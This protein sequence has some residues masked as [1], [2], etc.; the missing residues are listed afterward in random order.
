MPV[1]SRVRATRL[2]AA[3][4]ALL[5]DLSG[6]QLLPTFDLVGVAEQL[7]AG[8]A[9]ARPY[10]GDTIREGRG[11]R[12]EV[13]TGTVAL[14]SWNPAAGERRA[15]NPE[16]SYAQLGEMI[17]HQ[18][19]TVGLAGVPAFLD[20]SRLGWIGDLTR[21]YARWLGHEDPPPNYQPRSSRI[22]TW[23]AR[24]RNR[25]LRAYAELDYAPVSAQ[26]GVAGMLTLTYPAEWEQVVPTFRDAKRHLRKFLDRWSRAY[27]FRPAGLW[28]QEF[29]A[30]G[31][32][33]FH[34]FVSCPAL[35]PSPFCDAGHP[36]TVAAAARRGVPVCRCWSFEEWLSWAWAE[37]V[38]HPDPGEWVR[39][40]RA[41]TRVDFSK[42]PSCTDGRRLAVYFL[43]HG[44]K[45]IAGQE[46]Q[47]EPPA[48]WGMGI[49]PATGEVVDDG[50]TG[51]F[52]GYWGLDRKVAS[53]DIPGRDFY[54]LRRLCRRWARSPVTRRDVVDGVPTIRC[55]P[56]SATLPAAGR[57]SRR[58]MGSGG[59]G[60]GWLLVNDGPAFSA[61][62]SRALA[63]GRPL[64]PGE[65]RG[66]NKP[67][68]LP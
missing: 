62:L 5:L 56:A 50:G 29:Q 17:R 47:N 27:G 24:S 19:G 31:A 22:G 38:D 21:G 66:A 58:V 54:T 28:K 51:R 1:R 26:E 13:G 44:T 25:M 46:Y 68:G 15:D 43:K 65:T 6:G 9:P 12:L 41:G 64:S 14:R 35:A 8:F 53:V 40:L 36:Q 57:L 67:S 34:L 20:D 18:D 11:Y 33:H 23:S 61:A 32:P 42:A 4:A 39:H 45:T 52:W 48:L 49:D 37:V 63:A 30:R 60:G 3:E 2:D 55:G 10:R 7:A 59:S 16:D